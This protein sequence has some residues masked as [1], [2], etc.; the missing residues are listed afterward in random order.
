MPVF[1]INPS[2]VPITLPQTPFSCLMNDSQH[3]RPG[4][5]GSAS[6]VRRAFVVWAVWTFL[7]VF[8]ASKFYLESHVHGSHAP[9]TKALW[10]HL[11]EWYGWP[12][13]SPIIFYACRKATLDRAHWFA[14]SLIHLGAGTAT[15]LIQVAIF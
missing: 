1:R 5:A 10:W 3:E 9:W 12:V 6:W 15:S 14:S 13:C 4:I 11:M 8:F 7:G 2:C